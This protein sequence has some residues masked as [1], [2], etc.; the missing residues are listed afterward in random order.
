MSYSWLIL[1]SSEHYPFIDTNIFE[2]IAPTNW[3]ILS[4]LQ[5]RLSQHCRCISSATY[6]LLVWEEP[7]TP[8]QPPLNLV[9]TKVLSL[10]Q[11]T[12]RHFVNTL[13]DKR[14]R[15]ICL[16]T[17]STVRSVTFSHWLRY[18]LTVS[19]Y[20]SLPMHLIVQISNIILH[21]CR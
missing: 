10:L 1:T 20:Y 9:K 5:P 12:S 2:R 8:C 6:Q 18:V 11:T 17:Y 16:R 15:L 21:Y 3:A 14:A 7:K 19:G 13:S 4:Q